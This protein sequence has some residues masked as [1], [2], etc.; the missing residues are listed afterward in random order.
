MQWLEFAGIAIVALAL[1]VALPTWIGLRQQRFKKNI[2][3]RMRENA[4]EAQEELRRTRG[5]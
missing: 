2:A 5:E 1:F 4:N 3:V